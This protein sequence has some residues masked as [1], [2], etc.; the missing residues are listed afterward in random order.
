MAFDN[1]GSVERW[2]ATGQVCTYGPSGIGFVYFGTLGLLPCKGPIVT[3]DAGARGFN[4]YTGT[5]RPADFGRVVTQWDGVVGVRIAQPI[6]EVEVRCGVETFGAR[7]PSLVKDT[8]QTLSAVALSIKR[9]GSAK[10]IRLHA[11]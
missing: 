2:I 7:G 3:F 6:G 11:G 4:V 10:R 1:W 8:L 5:V 9:G